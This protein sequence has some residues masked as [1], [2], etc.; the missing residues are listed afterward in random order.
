MFNGRI[1]LIAL[2]AAT[3]LLAQLE[4]DL[5]SQTGRKAVAAFES[6]W[7]D[8]QA[9]KLACTITHFNPALDYGLRIWTGFQVA[10][11]AAEFQGKPD[12]SS[13]VVF[14]VTPQDGQAKTKYLWVPFEVPTKFPEGADLKKLELRM[15]GGFYVGQGKYSVDWLMA[16]GKGRRCKASWKLNASFKDVSP[17]VP[18]GTV[19]AQ[20]NEIWPGFPAPATGARQS[21][22]TIFLNAAPVWPRRVVT[23]L[24]PWDRQ[25]LLSSLNSLLRDGNFTSACVVVFDLERRNVIYRDAS[26]N[27]RSMRQLIRQ[28]AGVDLSTIDMATLKQ[29]SSP[30]EFLENM[31]RQEVKDPKQSDAFVFVGPTW[32]AGPKLPPMDPALRESLPKTWFLAFT[33][34]AYAGDGD[35]VTSLVK[36]AKGKV[37][38]IYR[39]ADLADGIRSLNAR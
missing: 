8:P 5:E 21:H 28:L 7:K 16:D 36:S 20:G 18:P 1:C 30:K 37:V 6:F 25:I 14:R 32:R 15:G 26:F 19:L 11:P 4:L 33:P 31:L 9:G 10:I 12:R 29:G 39:P 38:P 13:A 3:P 24:S 22:A 35:S 2:W 23:K 34:P 27:R 17:T